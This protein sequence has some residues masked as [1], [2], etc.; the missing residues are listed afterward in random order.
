[1]VV[2]VVNACAFYSDNPRSNPAYV[3]I[4]FLIT[5][6]RKRG[7]DWPVPKMVHGMTAVLWAAEMG[8]QLFALKL[9]ISLLNDNHV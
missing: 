6:K 7:R 9:F 2:V 8:F 3:K 1:M 4:I 5:N